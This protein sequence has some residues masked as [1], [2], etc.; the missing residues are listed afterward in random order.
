MQGGEKLDFAERDKCG[1]VLLRP[2]LARKQ[3]KPVMSLY[4]TEWRERGL[5]GI[6]PR[7]TVVQIGFF[8]TLALA[9][10]GLSL[11]V[12]SAPTYSDV[13]GPSAEAAMF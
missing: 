2:S 4:G 3:A 6:L 12:S 11:L 1:P 9:S 10:S 13:L 7:K 5:D 8:F